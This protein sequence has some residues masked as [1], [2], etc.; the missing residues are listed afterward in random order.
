MKAYISFHSCLPKVYKFYLLRLFS[1]TSF[2]EITNLGRFL[3]EITLNQMFSHVFIDLWSCLQVHVL[4]VF[5][6]IH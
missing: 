1:K 5:R 2:N 3:L 6:L 4:E